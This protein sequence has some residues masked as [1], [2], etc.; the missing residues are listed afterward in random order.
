MSYWLSATTADA[1]VDELE[2]HY[3][4]SPAP[5]GSDP[6]S[7]ICAVYHLIGCHLPTPPYPDLCERVSELIE[8]YSCDCGSSS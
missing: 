3:D 1:L 2:A 8:A 6:C 7:D 5:A 4:G